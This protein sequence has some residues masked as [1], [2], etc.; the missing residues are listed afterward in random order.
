MW[1]IHQSVFKTLGWLSFF[2]SF[3]L[4]LGFTL[5]AKA[6]VVQIADR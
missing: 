4:V 5:T 3:W 2:I 6:R 1:A